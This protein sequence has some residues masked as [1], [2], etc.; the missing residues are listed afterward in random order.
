[1]VSMTKGFNL[2]EMVSNPGPDGIA[3]YGARHIVPIWSDALEQIPIL[4]PKRAVIRT[5]EG[6]WHSVHIINSAADTGRQGITVKVFEKR[7]E[8]R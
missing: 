3:D 7:S 1:M 6:S 8:C 4:T 5:N 2:N